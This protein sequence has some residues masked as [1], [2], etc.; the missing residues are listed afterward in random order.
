VRD[1]LLA[2]VAALREAG[3]RVSVG[4]TLDAVEAVAV[5]GVERHVLR[6][7]LAATLVK[8]QA[9]REAFD[10][11]FEAWFPAASA[12]ERAGQRRRE[13]GFGGDRGP[14]SEETS[15]RGRAPRRETDQADPT[16]PRGGQDRR[17]RRGDGGPVR[18][19]SRRTE[20]QAG[21]AEDAPAAAARRLAA[22]ARLLNL[23][24]KDMGPREV[25]EAD[26]L[27]AELARRF[28]RRARRR[29]E[30]ARRGRLDVRRVVRRALSR[31]GVPVELLHR[32]PRPGTR[33]LVALVDLSYST[34]TAARF[35]LSL[36]A[37]AG[38]YFRR[39]TLLGFV[40]DLAEL[41]IEQGH[42]VPHGPL[43]LDARS[44]FGRV[45]AALLSRRGATLRRDTVLVVL[46]D[47]R[48]NRL[49]PRV[50]LLRRA[51]QR[52]RALVWV[53]PDPPARWNAGDSVIG[54]YAPHADAVLPG[55]DLRSLERALAEV[56]R[57]VA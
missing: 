34:A 15:G 18:R 53:N 43:D 40:A 41:S 26:R 2:F 19:E 52:V 57:R 21:E 47:A 3:L 35:L 32:R 55:G 24:F 13:A 44:D 25:E 9:D 23:P 46:G 56:A 7:A 22:R 45:L 54:L 42:V 11:V 49:A 38:R 48:N 27:V 33:D 36:V 6:E 39:V 28:R 12:A 31:G 51:R 10:R 50:D 20:G 16:V 4:E 17:R 30:R 5:V 1:R 14:G 8:D 29:Q 37:G